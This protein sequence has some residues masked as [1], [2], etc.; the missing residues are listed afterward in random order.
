MTT[1]ATIASETTLVTSPQPGELSPIEAAIMDGCN[2][3]HEAIGGGL[4]LVERVASLR[5]QLETLLQ[6]YEDTDGENHPNPRWAVPNQR[7]LVLSAAGEVDAAIEY[8]LIAIE[9]ADTPRRLEI[10]L[11]NLCERCIRARRYQ[12]AVEFF[13]RAVEVAPDRLPILLTGA[14]ALYLAGFKDDANKIF[15]ALQAEP[16][17]PTGELAAYLDF[18]ARLTEMADELPALARLFARRDLE[19][20]HA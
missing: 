17:T 5:G 15:E 1:F 12:E 7:A 6:R 14:Q 4:G 3:L 11:G 20:R 9:H 13:F 16:L 19:V 8:E 18:E 2:D 10:S